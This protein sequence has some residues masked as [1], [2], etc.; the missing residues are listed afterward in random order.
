MENK[1]NISS[2]KEKEKVSLLIDGIPVEID[3][4]STILQAAKK[5]GIHIPTLC[6]HEKVKPHGACR[7]C[8]VEIEKRGRKRIVASCA[9]PA[10]E[11]LTVN[12]ESEKVEQVRKILVE[13]YMAMFPSNAEIKALS[14]KY[15]LIDTRFKKENDYCILCGLCVRYCAEVKGNNAVG[16]VGRGTSKKVVFVPDSAYFKYCVDCMECMDICPTGVFPSNFGIDR[17]PQISDS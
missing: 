16:F 3:E 15:K 11:G 6:Y 5:A 9:Y 13:L 7:L 17:I 12:T 14:K 4:G 1:N 10:E 2:M 8:L